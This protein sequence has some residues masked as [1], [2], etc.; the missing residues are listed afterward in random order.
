MVNIS[1]DVTDLGGEARPGDK[2]V[3]WRPRMGGS[4][5]HA[6]RVI[7]TAPVTVFLTDGKA[8]VSD[9]EPG[10]MTVLLQCR[11]VESQ[12]PVTVG[13]PDGGHTVTLRALLESQFEYA[14]P[15]VSAV[16]E[17][18]SNAS[19]SEEAAIQAQIR[20]EA[21]ADRADA[22]VDDAINNGANLVRDEVKQ[23]A[24]RAVSARQAA[25]QSE[26]NAKASESAAATSASNAAAS[27]SAAKQ[28]ETNAGDYAAVATTAATEAV[29]AMDSVSDI[30][31]ANYATHEYVDAAAAAKADKSYVDNATFSIGYSD[32]RHANKY[33]KLNADGKVSISTNSVTTGSSPTNKAYVD[34]AISSAMG[35]VNWDRGTLGTKSINEVFDEGFH[36][37]G[38]NSYAT[39]E[40]GYPTGAAG[41]L[42]VTL[43]GVDQYIQVYF[44]YQGIYSR[45]YVNGSW[46]PWN[47]ALDV[48]SANSMI[49]ARLSAPE[50][51]SAFRGEPG[52]KGDP[53]PQG[54]Q[55]PQGAPGPQGEPGIPGTDAIPAAQAV[56]DYATTAGSPLNSVLTSTYEP[57]RVAPSQER[58]IY[59]RATGR[60]DGNGSWGA[61]YREISEALNSLAPDGAVISGRVVIDVG[62]G[63]Y[64]GDIR[65]PLTRGTAQDDFLR[66]IGRVD[67]N[68]VPVSRVVSTSGTGLMVEDGMSVWIENMKFT[69]AFSTAIRINRDLYAWFKNVHIDG[70][71]VGQKGI[72]VL[73]HARYAVAGGIIEN[74]TYAGIEEYFLV[75]RNFATVSS[76]AEQMLIRNCGIGLR[77]KEL[78]TGHLDYLRVEDCGTGVE[79]IQNSVANIKGMELR[80][81]QTGLSLVNSISHNEG[82]VV[83]GEGADANDREVYSVGMSGELRA[84][85]WT[86]ENMAQTANRG[87]RPLMQIAGD[88]ATRTISGDGSDSQIANFSSVLARP[89]FRT[90]GKRFEVRLLADITGATSESPIRVSFRIGNALIGYADLSSSGS[91]SITSSAVCVTEGAA[92]EHFISTSAEGVDAVMNFRKSSALSG[93]ASGVASVSISAK[94]SAGQTVEV[95]AVEMYG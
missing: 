41:V 10:E 23:D 1:V 78:C 60:S 54:L 79:L 8:T 15:I 80:R 34:A 91:A 59:V 46:T 52:E 29:D 17:A 48:M 90:E 32:N 9:V 49:D 76:S 2:V 14:P 71:G 64:S 94:A 6:G 44:S 3:F 56:A 18:A 50:V 65:V 61:P 57:K 30:I 92:A 27:E 87:H 20:S 82:A 63:D 45:R 35:T 70:E 74:C 19:A 88:Y 31:G 4:A 33:V 81:N 7:S 69:G 72:S 58:R 38:T 75:N 24:D 28:S 39:P 85:M 26:S 55:G 93:A 40:R 62:E 13:V 22:K 16:Q 73:A 21:A 36:G 53:G 43:V 25:T 51:Q 84:M 95:H 5:T 11:G 12:G 68:G 42:S 67:T 89:F 86:G 77:A 83:W 66:I 37:Q 47:A